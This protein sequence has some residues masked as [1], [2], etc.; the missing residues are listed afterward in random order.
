VRTESEIRD[1]AALIDAA[2]PSGETARAAVSADASVA[3]GACV[4]MGAQEVLYWVLGDDSAAT[5]M[6]LKRARARLKKRNK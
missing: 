6:M 1:A 4:V 5:V 2:Y 3:A